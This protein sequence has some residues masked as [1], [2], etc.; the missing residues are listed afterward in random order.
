MQ[1][2]R[3][4]RAVGAPTHRL[5]PQLRGVRVTTP[6]VPQLG[7]LVLGVGGAGVLQRSCWGRRGG[8]VVGDSLQPV[9]LEEISQLLYEYALCEGAASSLESWQKILSWKGRLGGSVG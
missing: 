8:E 4:R 9:H 7:L 1:G 5:W 2:G 6:E 3:H